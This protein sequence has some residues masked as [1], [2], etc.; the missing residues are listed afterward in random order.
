LIKTSTIAALLLSFGLVASAQ[1]ASHEVDLTWTASTDGGLVTV[2]RAPAACGTSGQVFAKLTT[3][4]PAGGP[5][6]DT[7]VTSGTWCY[8]VTATVNGAESLPS[9]NAAAT[10]PTAPP[11]GLV[12]VVVK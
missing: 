1:A 2:Y 3:S 4:A 10:V 11:T 7:A 8:Y 5:Y 12:T 6:K 9:N